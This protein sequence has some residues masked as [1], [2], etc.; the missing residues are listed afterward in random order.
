[1]AMTL[2]LMEANVACNTHTQRMRNTGCINDLVSHILLSCSPTCNF[3]LCHA[4]PLTRL[5]RLFPLPLRLRHLFPCPF[6]MAFRRCFKR[7]SAVQHGVSAVQP[8]VSAVQH[9]VSAAHHQQTPSAHIGKERCLQVW[10]HLDRNQCP[11]DSE[12]ALA[13]IICAKMASC[14][15]ASAI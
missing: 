2:L 15:N 9:C 5:R 14:S 6:A 12:N 4:W 13:Q 11:M 3:A 10:S 7:V 8:G 1:M